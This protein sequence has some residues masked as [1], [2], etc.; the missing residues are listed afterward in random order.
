[1]TFRS[2]ARHEAYFG[3]PDEFMMLPNMLRFAE[4]LAGRD[5]PSLEFRHQILEGETHL[6]GI[7]ATF[8]RGPLMGLAKNYWHRG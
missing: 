5:Y 1:M 6:S 4:T 8:S 7:P 3:G 2:D